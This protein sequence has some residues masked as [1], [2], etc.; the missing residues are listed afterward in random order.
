MANYDIASTSVSR[1]C[2]YGVVQF[3][4][5]RK[6]F[7]L[8]SENASI[9]EVKNSIVTLRSDSDVCDVYISALMSKGGYTTER[10]QI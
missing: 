1:F 6:E 8:K 9:F 2:K 7:S 4:N 10:K 3:Q 5:V